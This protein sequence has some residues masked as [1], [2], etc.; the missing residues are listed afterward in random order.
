MAPCNKMIELCFTQ[1]DPDRHRDKVYALVLNVFIALM[2]NSDNT[3][4]QL[5]PARWIYR[6]SQFSVPSPLTF[7]N[8][9]MA[10]GLLLANFAAKI[11]MALSISVAFENNSAYKPFS[12]AH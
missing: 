8:F 10:S 5:M 6:L 9:A 1:S 11:S 12:L 2:V 4:V 7:F 3:K